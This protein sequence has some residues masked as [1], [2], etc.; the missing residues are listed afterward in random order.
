MHE[1]LVEAMALYISFLCSSVYYL[2]QQ[3][4]GYLLVK[5]VL[6][7]YWRGSENCDADA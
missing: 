2:W 4:K 5:N 3:L 1:L 7:P 6:E